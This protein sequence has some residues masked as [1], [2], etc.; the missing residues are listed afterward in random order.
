MLSLEKISLQIS[1]AIKNNQL[2][3]VC[4]AGVSISL[5]DGGLPGWAGL[6]RSGFQYGE[7]KG[8]ITSAQREMW[9][10]QLSSSD[11]DDLLSAAEFMGRKLEA[12]SGDLYHRWLE[13]VFSEVAPTNSDLSAALR[14]LSA[15]NV[16]ICTLN[17][18]TLLEDVSE[19]PTVTMENPT[20]VASWMRRERG[21]ILH[22]HGAWNSPH[23]CIL[24]IRDY[25][26]TIN[27]EVRILIQRSLGAFKR[28][29]FIG[30]GETFSDPNFSALISW[31]RREMGTAA[32]QH[33]ALVRESEVAQRHSDATW[34]GFVEPVS[35][36]AAHSDLPGFINSLVG[37]RNIGRATRKKPNKQTTST[38]SHMEVLEAYRTF[39]L[40]DCGQMTIEGMR[41]DMDMAQRKF[42]LEKLFIPLKVS[43]CK[44]EVAANDPDR[45]QKLL[46]WSNQN[47]DPFPFGEV[48]AAHKHLALLA[49]PG[50]GKSLLL[51]R[52][53]VAYCDSKRRTTSDDK[54]PNLDLVPVLIRCREWR[55]HIH[56][57]ILTLLENMPTI[58][59]Q[60]SLR[61]LGDALVPLLKSGRVLLLVDGLDEIHDDA[62]RSTFVENLEKFLGDYEKIR[63]VVTSREAG[64]RLI[65]PNLARFCERRSI[66]PLDDSAISALCVHWHRLMIGE[67]QESISEAQMVA[68]HLMSDTSLRRLAENPLLLTML[69]VVK[70]GAGRLPPDRVS[71]YGRAVE[72][73]LDTWNIKGHEALNLKEAVPQL[74]CVAFQ[75]MQ[76]GKQTATESELLQLLAEARD[77]VDQIRRYATDTPDK[78]L[79]RV[80][81]RSSLLV[82]AG[83][84]QEHGRTVP[85]Y[86]FRHLTFQEY[87]AAVAVVEG[88]YLDFSQGD[89]VITPLARFVTSEEWKEVIPM[90]AVLARKQAEPLISALVAETNKTRY[91]QSSPTSSSQK[92]AEARVLKIPPAAARLIQCFDEEAEAAPATIEAGLNAV[93]Y[94]AG[95]ADFDHDWSVTVRGPYGRDLLHQLWIQYRTMDWMPEAKFF[96]SYPTLAR[97]RR[98]D[99]YWETTAGHDE[100][101][102]L[103]NSESDEDLTLGLSTCSGLAY[104]QQHAAVVPHVKTIQFLA[105]HKSLAVATAAS[106]SLGLLY[107]HCGQTLPPCPSATLNRM[108]EIWLTCSHK[109]TVER[110]S[111]SLLPPMS[112]SLKLW[113]PNVTT[114]DMEE[115]R[116]RCT[117]DSHRKN[118]YETSVALFVAFIYG[119]ILEKEEIAKSFLEV[120]KNN[121]EIR[122]HSIIPEI[123]FSELG[124]AGKACLAELKNARRKDKPR[125]PS[126]PA[127]KRRTAKQESQPGA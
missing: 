89:T 10:A 20:A 105:E 81:L 96:S 86:Q 100:I 57:P 107:Y 79:R 49:L 122:R 115:V 73:L 42:D 80:E 18:D 101:S 111:L 99:S 44:P 117:N 67:T 25:A 93:A 41:A 16:P 112:F 66:A 40:K 72:V 47:R 87:L 46:E 69:L 78:F 94:F 30:C 34:Q 35:Y 108:L 83:T 118:G 64:F 70:H 6:V 26:T 55:E 3:I 85:F 125:R 88:H 114:K 68:S 28:L 103:M 59:G 116:R 11:L 98:A 22:L 24:G 8:R 38:L 56:R 60:P 82:E 43:L 63:L 15:A 71:L 77:K 126:V 120:C 33:Y 37:S 102:A 5:T 123:L 4:G 21:G 113:K 75:L 91:L 97:C 53:V 74:A 9:D 19:L 31:L 50:G 36:G 84:Q 109:P 17:Y 62:Q 39:L 54:L 45:E 127:A 61:G 65:A 7:A 76:A 1:N 52:L 48:F 106:W 23:S 14:A 119:G 124:E 13:Q 12:P 51:K 32:P 92:R 121:S 104:S 58:T 110:L 29:L 90:A 95:R 2:V 27:D